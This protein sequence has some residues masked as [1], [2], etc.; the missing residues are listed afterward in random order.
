MRSPSRATFTHAPRLLRAGV[1][2]HVRLHCAPTPDGDTLARVNGEPSGE[3][4]NQV[5]PRPRRP[6][7]TRRRPRTWVTPITVLV[8]GGLLAWLALRALA[9]VAEAISPEGRDR[10]AIIANV[11]VDDGIDAKEA[12]QIARAFYKAAFGGLEGF[13]TEPVKKDGYWTSTVRTGYAGT[14]DP[15]PIVINP[16]TGAVSGPVGGS[17][18][19][20]QAFKRFVAEGQTLR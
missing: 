14:P 2:L 16:R 19:N 7:T 9:K 4:E 15:E 17:F 8:A 12:A 13:A 3:R 10:L 18:A 1:R 20:F 6:A 5:G 11:T